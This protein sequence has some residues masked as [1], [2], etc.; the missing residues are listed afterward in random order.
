VCISRTVLLLTAACVLTLSPH[1]SA[2]TIPFTSDNGPTGWIYDSS[3]TKVGVFFF[4]ITNIPGSDKS[5][6]IDIYWQWDQ[7]VNLIGF[8]VDFGGS[9]TVGPRSI[10]SAQFQN[11]YD[12]S[13]SSDWAGSFT[14]TTATFHAN[15]P[16]DE[17]SNGQWWATKIYFNDIVQG[18]L[19]F[20]GYL[21]TPDSRGA[22]TPE[23]GTILMSATGIALAAFI[24]RKRRA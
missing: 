2:G 15:G 6:G 17:V 23:P 18:T 7:P 20:S 11:E 4:N 8:H 19:G 13:K 5:N 3:N 21:V 12:F 16:A 22:A 24:R 9:F 14:S 1:A 10:T